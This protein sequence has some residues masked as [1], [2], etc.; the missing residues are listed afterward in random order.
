MRQYTHQQA[1]LKTPLL[2]TGPPNVYRSVC[3]CCQN[4]SLLNFSRFSSCCAARGFLSVPPPTSHLYYIGHL[5]PFSFVFS[6][7][8][9]SREFSTITQSLRAI[10]H[11]SF[12][13]EKEGGVCMCTHVYVCVCVCVWRLWF[14]HKGEGPA[15]FYVSGRTLFS[16]SRNIMFISSIIRN[17]CLTRTFLKLMCLKEL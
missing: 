17:R 1:S 8:H 9:P 10:K 4:C 3:S 7:F 13:L 11:K 12:S 16:L 5:G 14:N 2:V 15:L 6:L